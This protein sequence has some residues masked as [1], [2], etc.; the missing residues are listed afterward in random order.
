MKDQRRIVIFDVGGVLCSDAIRPKVS[1]LIQKYGLSGERTMEKARALRPHVDLGT[2]GEQEFWI[3]LLASQGVAYEPEDLNLCSYAVPN[4]GI[5]ELFTRM[6]EDEFRLGILSNDSIELFQA[7]VAA[8]GIR[9]RLDVV[10]V[11]AAVRLKKPDPRMFDCVLGAFD[12]PAERCFFVDDKMANVVA[13]RKK[14]MDAHLFSSVRELEIQLG[15]PK[16]P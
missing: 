8:L 5:S 16:S 2:L 14:G 7:R 11:S 3:R 12:A 15:L 10:V 13:A 4:P 9:K 1:D 6:P